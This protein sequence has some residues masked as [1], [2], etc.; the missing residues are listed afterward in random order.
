MALADKVRLA[1]RIGRPEA[2]ARRYFVTNGFDGALTLLGLLMG[3]RIAGVEAPEVVLAAGFGTAVALGVSGLSSA[4][5]SETAERR[6]ELDKLKAAMVEPL[7]GS[8]HEHAALLAPVLVA[9][10]NGLSPFLI[11]QAILCP[12]WLTRTGT[13]LPVSPVDAGIVT[14]LVLVFL[15]GTFLGHVG[16]THW[17]WSGLRALMLAVATVGLI[18][19]LGV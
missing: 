10:V 13:S 2:I 8:A 15:L 1:L 6:Q 9:L 4:W 16:G 5:I 3:F 14:A 18:M 12:L 7:E 17:F 19:L 11:A